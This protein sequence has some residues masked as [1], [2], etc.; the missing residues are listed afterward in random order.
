MP[1]GPLVVGGLHPGQRSQLRVAGTTGDPD[2]AGVGDIGQQGAEQHGQVDPES[3]AGLAYFLRE[4]APAQLRLGPDRK[5][6]S[7][8]A[9]GTGSAGQRDRR[10]FEATGLARLQSHLRAGRGE[11]EQLLGVEH[12]ERAPA[13]GPYPGR[14]PLRRP[15]SRRR[16]SP[17]RRPPAR[18]GGGSDDVPNGAAPSQTRL[19]RSVPLATSACPGAYPLTAPEIRP[20][21]MYLCNTKNKI[22]MGRIVKAD[23]PS[24]NGNWVPADNPPPTI[25]AR[26][27]VRV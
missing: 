20:G 27:V 2:G 24:F 16:S 10:P 15:R 18:A 14:R 19:A 8:S 9:P 11:V 7:R 22:A 3:G 1:V 25:L 4:A 5:M 21:V 13:P 6:T 12:G 26:P 23:A 17:R